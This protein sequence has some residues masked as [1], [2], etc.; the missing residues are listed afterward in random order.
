M[1]N[2]LLF[3][4]ELIQTTPWP[5]PKSCLIVAEAGINHNGSL[6]IARQL[7]DLAKS[8]GCD[9]IKFQKRTIDIVYTPDFLSAPRESPWGTT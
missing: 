7:I 9:A 5:V 8:A 3:A 6:E 2:R 1:S 4:Y